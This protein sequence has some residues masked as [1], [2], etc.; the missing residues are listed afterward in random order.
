MRQSSIL[1]IKSNLIKSM[2]LISIL[3]FAFDYRL[4]LSYQMWPSCFACLLYQTAKLLRKQSW[5]LDRVLKQ[6]CLFQEL[7]LLFSI[8]RRRFFW[9]G[10]WRPR[11]YPTPHPGRTINNLSY[12]PRSIWS[13]SL[14]ISFI[15]YRC[16]YFVSWRIFLDFGDLVELFNPAKLLF[17]ISAILRNR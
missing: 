4:S 13:P 8:F 17:F 15:I 5:R 10:C 7:L 12:K 16:D 2:F 3:L 11:D 1:S 14:L 9:S 6:V